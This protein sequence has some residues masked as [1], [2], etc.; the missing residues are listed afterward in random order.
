MQC[1]G[2]S[3]FAWISVCLVGGV[4]RREEG[5]WVY[6]QENSN[7]ADLPHEHN[8]SGCQCSGILKKLTAGSVGRLLLLFLL[9]ELTAYPHSANATPT[10]AWRANI[11]GIWRNVRRFLYE[12][13]QEIVSRLPSDREL[14]EEL[15][16][17]CDRPRV[18]F[19]L[20][21]MEV[22]FSIKSI[23]Q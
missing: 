1:W 8:S 4:E 12:Y 23:M 3:G 16:M 22:S 13:N 9:A 19:A 18:R 5:V 2:R 15:R 17:S 10:R 6:D 21:V 7:H 14:G 20:H 11:R